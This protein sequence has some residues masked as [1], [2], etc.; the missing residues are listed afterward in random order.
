[1]M[2]MCP[3]ATT[4]S[5]VVSS[6]RAR[7]DARGWTRVRSRA[8]VSSRVGDDVDG[9]GG[10]GGRGNGDDARGFGGGGG[11]DDDD[12]ENESFD[13]RVVA[14]AAVTAIATMMTASSA[15]AVSAAASRGHGRRSRK[16]ADMSTSALYG[17]VIFYGIKI[18]LK[19]LFAPV[20]LFTGT[21][22]LLFRMRALRV[23]PGMMYD[24]FVKPY[25]PV[26]YRR[27]LEEFSVGALK[28]KAARNAMR[29]GWWDKQERRFWTCAHRLLPACD[30]RIGERAFIFGVVLAGLA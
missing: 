3:R 18:A 19:R 29:D 20:L 2:M 12:D 1:M 5:S 7:V 4:C 14:V 23:S 21:T 24:S 6:S 13:G 26:E 8:S 30:S 15:R 17:F 22:Q 9:G 16:L 10:G 11:D 25:L 27:N 28:S